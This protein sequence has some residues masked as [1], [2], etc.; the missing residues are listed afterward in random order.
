MNMS[1]VTN[2]NYDPKI[3]AKPW[4]TMNQSQWPNVQ[5]S[6]KMETSNI[7]AALTVLKQLSYALHCQNKQTLITNEGLRPL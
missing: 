1:N 6:I 4:D 3:T 2:P 5:I 7:Q